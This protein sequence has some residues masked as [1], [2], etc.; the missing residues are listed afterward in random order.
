MSK[1][2]RDTYAPISP[3]FTPLRHCREKGQYTA[4]LLH[5]RPQGV[6]KEAACFPLKKYR[7]GNWRNEG[8]ARGPCFPPPKFVK[9][10]CGIVST[11]FLVLKLESSKF[12]G[13]ML[14]L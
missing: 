6:D 10:G 7:V 11:F 5:Q 12:V 9:V 4:S 8:E 14:E 13:I 2:G 1:H 3:G